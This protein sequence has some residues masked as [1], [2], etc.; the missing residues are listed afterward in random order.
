MPEPGNHADYVTEKEYNA[1]TS[2]YESEDLQTDSVLFKLIYMYHEDKAMLDEIALILGQMG[3]GLLDR[4]QIEP[5]AGRTNARYPQKQKKRAKETIEMYKLSFVPSEPMGGAG[6]SLVFSDLSAGTRRAIRIVTS[7]LFDK[8]SL[9]LL[10]QPE[11]SVHPGLLRKLIDQLRTYSDKT[12]VIFTTHSPEVLDILRPEE[13]LLV[14]AP[15]G[16]T[17]ARRLSPE[18]I[19]RAKR[20]LKNEGSLSDFLEPL[21]EQ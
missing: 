8:R 7:M 19:N 2:R 15:G 14:T 12:Q 21:G 1:R 13:V 6:K 5:I 10:E 20:F 9:M 16:S 3:L 18:E 11:D 17:Q 4:I